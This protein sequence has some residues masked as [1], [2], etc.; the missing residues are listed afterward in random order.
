MTP[1]F[2]SPSPAGREKGMRP[3]R[4]AVIDANVL[5]N[6]GVCDL[7]LRLAE[8]PRLFEPCWSEA[9]LGETERTHLGR[10]GWPPRVSRSFQR[11]IREAFPEAR[12][13]GFEHL[14]ETCDNE[15]GD[16]HVLACARRA[17]AG[18]IITFNLRHF[19]S[20]ALGP[21]GIRSMHPQDYLMMLHQADP[22]AVRRVIYEIAERRRLSPKEH[23]RAL[24][25]F[26]PSFTNQLRTDGSWE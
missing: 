5:A 3:D 14:I 6:F 8:P 7:L 15:D 23:L 2:T 24:G 18:A 19:P 13:R 22:M 26:L 10:L 4:K 20:S 17:G 9:I 1:G 11:R 12:V 25:R 21:W 16:R